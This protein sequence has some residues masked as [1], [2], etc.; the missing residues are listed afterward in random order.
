MAIGYIPILG[1]PMLGIIQN[2]HEKEKYGRYICHDN[3][4]DCF[5]YYSSY[6]NRWIVYLRNNIHRRNKQT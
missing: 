6:C 3:Y 1:I 2:R 5:K 4:L